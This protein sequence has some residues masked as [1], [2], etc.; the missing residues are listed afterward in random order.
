MLLLDLARCRGTR[1]LNCSNEKADLF[2]DIVCIAYKAY[3][4][5]NHDF[6][7]LRLTL[8]LASLPSLPTRAMHLLKGRLLVIALKPIN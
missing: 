2:K 6:L 1:L 3:N 8:C 5:R 7:I 4:K